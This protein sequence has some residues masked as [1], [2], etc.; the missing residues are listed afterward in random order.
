MIESRWA[1]FDSRSDF[2]LPE[3]WGNLL[4][5]LTNPL[6]KGI[7]LGMT[8]EMIE[9]VIHSGPLLLLVKRFTLLSPPVPHAFSYSFENHLFDVLN[10]MPRLRS[11]GLRLL[12]R[13]L[14]CL[15]ILTETTG[16]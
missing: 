10:L 6:V 13:M 11:E 9:A 2:R 5:S 15:R 7:P 8:N 14:K 1:S 4:L 16:D 12:P 3:G